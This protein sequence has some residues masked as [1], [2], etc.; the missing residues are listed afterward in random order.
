MVSGIFV[1]GFRNGYE[2]V[3][4]ELLVDDAIGERWSDYEVLGQKTPVA[5]L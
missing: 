5:A 4:P 3:H 1:Y 2:D